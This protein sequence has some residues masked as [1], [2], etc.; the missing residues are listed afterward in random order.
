MRVLETHAFRLPVRRFV[1]DLF[2]KNVMRRIVLDDDD[3][4]DDDYED[5][6]GNDGSQGG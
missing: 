2:G 6:G 5:D 4:D 3:D 1:L